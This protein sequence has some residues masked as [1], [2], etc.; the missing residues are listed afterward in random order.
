MSELTT[1][2]IEREQQPFARSYD[3][4]KKHTQQ[5]FTAT[6]HRKIAELAAL[7]SAYSEDK[8]HSNENDLL[9][10][11]MKNLTKKAKASYKEVYKSS[12]AGDVPAETK[13]LKKTLL[14]AK[15]LK[16]NHFKTP[17]HLLGTI[18]EI[19][20]HF[21]SDAVKDHRR[22]A[23]QLRTVPLEISGDDG[24][25]SYTF[26]MP[27]TSCSL[28][29][30][31]PSDPVL[32]AENVRKRE[33]KAKN[34]LIVVSEGQTRNFL[35][36]ENNLF[37]SFLPASDVDLFRTLEDCEWERAGTAECLD[38]DIDTINQQ[39]R[40]IAKKFQQMRM[41]LI[42]FRLPQQNREPIEHKDDLTD[43]FV[44]FADRLQRLSRADFPKI[45]SQAFAQCAEDQSYLL[46]D[47][48]NERHEVMSHLLRL[49]RKTQT[50]Q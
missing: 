10:W 8:S 25:V 28:V 50:T 6:Q 30:T 27:S 42:E 13:A 2:A 15:K 22:K 49:W 23:R 39:V 29:V 47:V 38:A 14:L 16:S 46:G 1:L 26:E 18:G 35:T 3:E 12:A 20:S 40:R 36:R 48:L 41:L 21:Y 5:R 44:R 19:C 24:E 43:R 9:E 33:Q 31:L 17:D 7:F 45:F 37:L 34:N 32:A 11:I 4:W